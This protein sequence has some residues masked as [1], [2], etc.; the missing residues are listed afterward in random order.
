MRYKELSNGPN[1]EK[2]EKIKERVNRARQIQLERFKNNGVFVN[3]QMN[4]KSIRKYC[5]LND[6]CRDL[7]KTAIT[8]MGFSARCYDKILKVSRTI[9][10]V[11]G[12]YEIKTDHISE[13]IQYRSLD[14]GLFFG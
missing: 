13:A 7:L 1:G 3:S 6:A 2:S 4:Y 5:H 14:R 9:A 10:D 8:E 11:E 12:S